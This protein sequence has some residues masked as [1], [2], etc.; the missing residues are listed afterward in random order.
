VSATPSAP[1]GKGVI[2]DLGYARYAGERR[3]PATLWRVIM[4]QHLAYAWKTLWRFKPWVA[5][6]VLATAITGGFMYLETN[7]TMRAINAMGKGVRVVDGALLWAF[8]AYRF[9]AF[10]AS[11]TIGAA[12]IARDLE[13]GAFTFYFS[14]PVR[15]LDYVL[16]KLA[17]QLVLMAILFVAGPLLLALFRIGL[18][19][20]NAERLEQLVLIPRVLIIGGLGALVFG[21]VPLAIS[22]LA[23]RR[24]L[25]LASWAAYYIAGITI[26]GAL[27]GLFWE[28]LR[29]LD[30]GQALDVVALGVLGFELPKQDL[31]PLWAAITGL[32]LHAVAATAIVVVQ[33]KRLAEGSVGA[34]S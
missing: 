10:M 19:L 6:A 2:H 5:V 13:S 23:G 27:G 4:R 26:V 8:S 34:S 3:G 12:V 21:T 7:E 30:P 31:P 22:A 11:M 17:A 16:G 32:M 24:T 15:P 18:S 9:A 20:D 33:V 25:A 29:A 14:R 1:G 28:P